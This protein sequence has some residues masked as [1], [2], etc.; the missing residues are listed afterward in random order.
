MN[1]MDGLPIDLCQE[2]FKPV[3]SC[4]LNAPVKTLAPIFNELNK[5]LHLY[6]L[7]PTDSLNPVRK[8]CSVQP[9]REVSKDRFWHVD[10]KRP[11]FQFRYHRALR[12]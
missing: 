8:A 12:L 3:E 10:S 9:I 7:I 6:S 4:L 11:K 5:A 1:K 2:M